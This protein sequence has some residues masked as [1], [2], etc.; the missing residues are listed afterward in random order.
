GCGFGDVPGRVVFR[1]QGST[2]TP[3]AVEPREWCDDRISVVVPRGA[4][5]GM[6]LEL[7]P[8]TIE[9]C[10]RFLEYG[11]IGCIEQ[12]FEGTSPEILRFGVKAHTEGECLQPGE[13]VEIRWMTCAADRVRVEIV[14]RDTGATIAVRDPA[15]PSGF[16]NFEGTNFTTTTRTRVQVTA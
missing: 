1:A 8:N 5:C 14:N 4:G 16:W 2:N 11:R 9:V 6:W 13:P 12:G 3:I 15:D 10:G 7:P